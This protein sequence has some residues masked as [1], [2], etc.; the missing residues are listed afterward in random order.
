MSHIVVLPGDGIGPEVTAEA[1]QCLQLLS[2][3]CGLGLTFEERDFGGIAIDR[4]GVPLPAE[5]LVAT[6]VM[7]RLRMQA[8]RPSIVWLSTFWRPRRSSLTVFVPSTLM[9]GVALPAWR[10][11]AAISS[12]II[13]PF[14]KIWK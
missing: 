3:R 7:R 11:C 4:H 5:T 2:D 8:S 9:S 14:V 1:Q 6:P 12:V 10:T 13:C